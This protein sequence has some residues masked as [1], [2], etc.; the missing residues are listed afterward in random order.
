MAD[1]YNKDDKMYELIC[2]DYRSL[3]IISRFN[4]SLGVKDKTIEEVCM[5][6]NVDCDTFLTVVNFTKYGINKYDSIPK[7]SIK[8]LTNYLKQAHSYY[9]DFLL[10][11][12]RKKLIE[13][14]N[15]STTNDVTF[16]ILKFFDEYIDEIRKHMER[17][18]EEIFPYVDTLLLGKTTEPISIEM[19]LLHQSSIEQK[20]SELKNIIIK[21]YTDNSNNNLLNTVLYDIFLCEEDLVNHC[22]L[23]ENVFIPAVARLEQKNKDKQEYGVDD[24]EEESETLTDREKEVII[25]VVKGLSNKEIADKLFISIN[26]VTT[27]RR[28]IARKLDIHSPSGLTIYAIVNKLVDVSEIKI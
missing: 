13:A 11:S 23:E 2:K 27:H 4:I 19:S 3:Q 5:E 17:E 28:N 22:K 1:R 21:Y 8:S 25:C 10:P 15:Y 7:L 18:N 12:I 16:L 20:L 6:Q 9:L 26:T 14:I 24:D